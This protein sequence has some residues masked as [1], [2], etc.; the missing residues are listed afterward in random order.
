[1]Y[2]VATDRLW[3][4]ETFRRSARGRL[5]EIF[6]AT[7][8]AQDSLVRTTGYSDQELQNG[9]ASLDAE[10]QDVING[11]VAGFNRRI[12]EIRKDP[13][14]LPFE[15]AAVGITSVTLENWTYQD[16]LAWAVLMMRNFD[17]EAQKSGQIANAALYQG[18]VV[19]Y[20]PTNGPR[21]FEDLRWLNDPDATT[22][23]HKP[24]RVPLAVQ[25]ETPSP[26]MI[27]PP[28]FPDMREVAKRM[29]ETQSEIDEN[30]KK[31]NAYVKMGSYAWTI[32]G[33]KTASGNP[34]IYSG[35]QM[36]FTVPSII[37]EGSIRAAGLNVSGMY[38][39]GLPSIVI[40]RTP[41]HAWSMQ[42]GH[43]HTVD[44]YMESASAMTLNRTETIKVRGAADVVLPIYRT[45]RG[46]VI[47]ATPVIS[48]KYSHWGYE[49]KVI[50]AYLGLARAT[51]MDQFG[52]AIEHVPLSQHFTYADR[53]G[54]IAYW[55]SGRDPIRPY[56]EWRL[57][58]GAVGTALEWNSANLIPRSTDR[59]TSRGYY[60]GWNNKANAGYNNKWNN[61][62]YSF[63]VFHRA[64]VL[65]DYLSATNNLTFAQ[66]RD[67]A[68]DI[69]ATDS[70][71]GGGNPWK[72]AS[73]YFV[74]AVN[75]APDA[76]IAARSAAL[77]LLAAW[78]GHFVDGGVGSWAA[79]TNRA[80]AWVLMD[81]WIKEVLR[82]TFEELDVN[83]TLQTAKN[84]LVLF[85]V[86]LH[87]LRPGGVSNYYNWFKNADPAAPQT[88]NAII[89]KALDNTL[90]ALGAKPWGTGAR[91]KIPYNHAMLGKVWEMPFSSRSTYAHTVEYAGSGPVKIQSMFPLGASGTILGFPAPVFDPNFFTMTS[92]YDGFVY[93]DFPLFVP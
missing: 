92:V 8:L 70:F 1:G 54:N 28:S 59:N 33:S 3:Q 24:I 87:G 69:A 78:D 37:G 58:Q 42:V 31:I 52:A 89:V 61:P 2:A 12:A 26:L 64:H 57:P 20:G 47:N 46:P 13:S 6:G 39:A 7:Q 73:E 66:V 65:D 38:I 14:L 43:A 55:M 17:P 83:A 45:A 5:A 68:L 9:F 75:T 40:G 84:D 22:Y 72:F 29:A 21:M 49:F 62:G 88:A 30:L 79:G 50:K 76:P 19:A 67:L 71:G 56:G 80:D 48:W 18:L 51:S 91:G 36:G 60:T 16:V 23:I 90:A 63:G 4:A 10:E 11:Y 25:E 77:A 32:K 44:Y 86:L 34:I 15:F 85:N 27:N 53:N 93:R 81:A 35:P 41:H 74:T 82:L